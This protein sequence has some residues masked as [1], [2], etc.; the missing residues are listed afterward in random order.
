[1]RAT[2]FEAE[3]IFYDKDGNPSE[4][5]VPF[6][7]FEEMKELIERNLLDFDPT[8]TAELREAIADAD[9]GNHEAFIPADQV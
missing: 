5:L 4:V 2:V 7:K 8:E 9:A 3:K 6:V 1:M